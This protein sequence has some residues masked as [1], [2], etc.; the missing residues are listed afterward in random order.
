MLGK[1]FTYLKENFDSFYIDKHLNFARDVY[2]LPLEMH[3]FVGEPTQE[4]I[5]RYEMLI[6]NTNDKWVGVSLF[7]ETDVS[8]AAELTV[9]L[10]L[11][12]VYID[13]TI[14]MSESSTKHEYDELFSELP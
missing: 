10:D 5:D 1:T 13:G 9:E 4:Q 7:V 12:F 6:Y 8:R 14:V 3:Y 11:P 2:F